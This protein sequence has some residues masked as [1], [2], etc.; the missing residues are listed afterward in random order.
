[1]DTV[2]GIP[3]HPL[4]VHVPVVL[5]PLT[6]LA[7]IGAVAWRRGRRALS[8]AA[9][10]G[11]LVS[12]VGAQLATMSGERLEEHVDATSAIHQHA[13]LGEAT[14]TLAFAMLVAAAAY[15]AREWAGAARLPGAARVRA[16][17]AP[18]AVGAVLAVALVASALL[19][20]TWD[21]RTGHK[22]AEAV[23][24]DNPALTSTYGGGAAAR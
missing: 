15:C 7:A 1:V 16:M 2:F 8:A 12:F 13:E 19:A 3:A 10:G 11:A 14:R 22:G 20:T 23:W 24:A 6:L 21:V 18:R 5:I 9:F 4:I 17:L